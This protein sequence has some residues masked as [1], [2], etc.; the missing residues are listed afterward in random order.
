MRIVGVILLVARAW[1]P[2]ALAHNERPV[3]F[4]DH[5]KGSVPVYRTTGPALVVCKPDSA[6]RIARLPAAARARNL[7]LLPQCRSSHIQAAV[8]A[9]AN[10]TRILILPG[11]YREEP[12]RAA[13][14]PDPACTGLEVALEAGPGTVPGYEYQRRCPNAQ[15]LIAIVG[16]SN[17]DG[18]C[19]DRCNLQ[20]EGTGALVSDV[21]I[22]GDRRKLNAIRGD[23]ADGLYPGSGPEGGC[24]RY[25]IEIRDVE[26]G[27][28]LGYSGTAG[29]GIWVHDSRFHHNTTGIVMDSAFPG[30]PG[31]PQD[32]AKFERWRRGVQLAWVPAFNRGEGGS[33]E[34]V[35]HLERELPDERPLRSHDKPQASELIH[36]LAPHFSRALVRVVVERP[37]VVGDLKLP[38]APASRADERPPDTGARSHRA[39]REVHRPRR[40]AL[41]VAPARAAAP[42]AGEPVEDP[43][44]TVEEDPAEPGRAHGQRRRRLSAVRRLNGAATD[45]ARSGRPC[46]GPR[47]S[48]GCEQNDCLRHAALLRLVARKVDHSYS[49]TLTGA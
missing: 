3:S 43:A 10:G 33:G 16:D 34:G 20:L 11:V 27:D 31:M 44:P 26:A 19:D 1:P 17:G 13:P 40:R 5:T 45:L 24:A 7:A 18:V 39:P 8:N 28:L 47:G 42:V 6:G 49:G 29:N 37:A 23:R 30:H 25:G 46:N 9:A 32:C 15:N 12:S 35:R 14:S 21:L 41:A 2:V 4:P 38:V 48:N 36:V 22:D